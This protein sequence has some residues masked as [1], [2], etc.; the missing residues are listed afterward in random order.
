MVQGVYVAGAAGLPVQKRSG[1]S[2][3]DMG[4]QVLRAALQDAAM[5]PEEIQAVYAGNMLADEL[6]GQKHLGALIASAAGLRDTE[7]LWVRAA[8]ASGAAALR[9]GVLAIRS[10]AAKA[11]AV[12]GV[13]KMSEG[14]ATA[15]LAKALD[16]KSEI[17]QGQ[18][19]VSI[20]AGLMAQYM[21]AYG[22]THDRFAGFAANAHQNAC[23][24]EHALFRRELSEEDI[25]AARV[26]VDPIRLYDCA[27]VCDGA[28]AVILSAE[29]RTKD[30]V[31][32]AA[33]SVACEEFV[34]ERRPEPLR[35]RA[36]ELSCRRAYREAGLDAGDMDLFELHDAFS[37]MACLSLEACGFAERGRGWQ[38][39]AEGEIGPN[40]RIPIATMGGL[41]ARGHPIGATALYQIYEIRQQLLGQ[42]GPNQVPNARTALTQSIGGA[43]T[44]LITHILQRA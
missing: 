17:D 7:A 41:K 36:S 15:A 19:M 11:V 33:S 16:R 1:Q 34:V 14:D 26:I 24:T 20:N 8:T 40:G 4:S 38:L 9:V 6:Q 43:G 42:A 28:A 10:G 3:D 29:P 2:L 22:V 18:T 21:R 37:I 31:S 5:E 39:A 30:A 32:I 35:L 13:E 27:P 23:K 25:N 44:T 12:V